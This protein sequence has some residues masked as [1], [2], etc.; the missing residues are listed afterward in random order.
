MQ[1]CSNVL[2]YYTYFAII[3]HDFTRKKY[4]AQKLSLIDIVFKI[5]KKNILQIRYS[6][7]LIK[8]DS[9]DAMLCASTP[10]CWKYNFYQCKVVIYEDPFEPSDYDELSIAILSLS[11]LGK[12]EYFLTFYLG[13]QN[14]GQE[15]TPL[16]F[17]QLQFLRVIEIDKCIPDDYE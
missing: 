16:G 5:Y 11:I 17:A 10:K 13:K 2:Y 4:I 9:P 14:H 12:K 3:Y 15:L 7:L 6:L 8:F 1:K